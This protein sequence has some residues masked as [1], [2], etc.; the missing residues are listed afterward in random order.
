M[1]AHEIRSPLAFIRQRNY[2]LVQGLAGPLGE[3]Q[4]DFVN[5][6]SKKIEPP[7]ELINDLLDVAKIE[8]GQ[9]V[10][11]RSKRKIRVWGSLNR[12]SP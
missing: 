1:V 6:G 7:L 9:F 8:A 3:K 5:R 11:L 12:N 2:V 4:Q 10:Q